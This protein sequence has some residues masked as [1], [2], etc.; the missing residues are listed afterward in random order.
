MSDWEFTGA[1]HQERTHRHFHY[2]DPC[3]CPWGYDEG[4]EHYGSVHEAAK[5]DWL[6]NRPDMQDD[7]GQALLDKLEDKGYDEADKMLPWIIREYRKKR[8]SFEHP[9]RPDHYLSYL[10]PDSASCT[11]CFAEDQHTGWC[12]HSGEVQDSQRQRTWFTPQH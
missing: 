9:S 6:R 12:R 4:G 1:Y 11:H 10:H 7:E 8:L 2:G 5:L 3:R